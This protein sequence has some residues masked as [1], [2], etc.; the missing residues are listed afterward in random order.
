VKVYRQTH[1]GEGQE[2]FHLPVRRVTS[3]YASS[4]VALLVVQPSIAEVVNKTL[5]IHN[6]KP[7]IQ[8][9]VNRT[10]ELHKIA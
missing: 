1:R 4:L 6:K 8:E 7:T 10:L 2:I 3:L 5:S 9:V